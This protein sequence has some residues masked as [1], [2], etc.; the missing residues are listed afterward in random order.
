M[1]GLCRRLGATAGVVLASS[2]LSGATAQPA[3]DFY[4]GKQITMIIGSSTGGGYDTQGRLVAR[5]IGRLMPGTPSVI[6]QNMPGAGS[7]TATNHL[8][9]VAAK[10][11]SVFGLIQREVLTA[12]LISPENVRFDITKFNWVGNISSET[13]V[14]VAW[15]TSPIKTTEDLF[16]TEMIVGGTGPV[17]DTETT[18]RLLNALTGT[19][20]RIVSGYQ[21]TTEILLAMER[22]EV[23]GI[24]DWSWSNIKSRNMELVK[25]GKI[26]LLM[27][28]ALTKDPDLPNVPFMLDFAKSPE[29][30]KLME[31]LLAAKAVA[32]PVAAPPELAADRLKSLRDAF[33]ALKSDRDFLQDSEKSKLEVGLTSG[34]EVD[35]VIAL[36]GGTPKTETDRLLTFIVPNR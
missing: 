23:M 2:I 7:I 17:I 12:H 13:G 33:I 28:A 21:G 8:Y 30:R 29:D 24:G 19:K 35:K 1:H 34:A 20:F 5:H 26:R 15:H 22:G 11:G 18:P 31:F 16:K 32:R 3:T 6:V 25:E 10:D 14:I 9:N 27:Q 4:K 36:I